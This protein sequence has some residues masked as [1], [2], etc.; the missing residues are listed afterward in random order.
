MEARTAS[1]IR[2]LTTFPTEGLPSP[3]VVQTL[4]EFPVRY[5]NNL[6][7][8]DTQINR[9]FCCQCARDGYAD[10]V[11]MVYRPSIFLENGNGHGNDSDDDSDRDGSQEDGGDIRCFRDNCGH[12]PCCNCAVGPTH[13]L[14]RMTRTVGGLY[15]SPAFVDPA[16]WEC[17]CGEWVRNNIDE[18]SELGR[19][20]CANPAGCPFRW[21]H[22]HAHEHGV[23]RAASVVMNR[24][25]Q[26]LG[27]ADQMVMLAGGPWYWQRRAL[28]D[29]VCVLLAELRRS[30]FQPRGGWQSQLQLPLQLD[31][32]D[33]LMVWAEGE[34][35]PRY[36]YRCAPPRQWG[37][38]GHYEE[39]FVRYQREY[40]LGMPLAPRENSNIVVSHQNSHTIISRGGES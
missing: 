38:D 24:Y 33:G 35:V 25:G 36:P 8:L 32:Q 15:S 30:E 28:G 17:E 6:A 34:A 37:D 20:V 16:H 5:P 40:L 3:R 1:R 19:T 12:T 11:G 39:R 26:R 22:A 23:L 18:A 7:P 31:L 21:P 13:D 9:W 29:A 27:T 2:T 14:R 10:P 4:A